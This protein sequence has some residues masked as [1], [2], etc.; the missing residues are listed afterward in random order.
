M[1]ELFKRVMSYLKC[2]GIIPKVIKLPPIDTLTIRKVEQK[3]A[4]TIPVELLDFY[5]H[6][7][8]GIVFCWFQ[9]GDFGSLNIPTP[10]DLVKQYR[11]WK[12]T[13]LWMDDYDF[14]HVK[15]RLCA[16]KTYQ[17]M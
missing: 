10:K 11:G 4:L 12:E 15:N 7:G 17:R 6:Y 5:L 2:L 1:D 3:L 9:G 16:K 14:P 13:V 8:S